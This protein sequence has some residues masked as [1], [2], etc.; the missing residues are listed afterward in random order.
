MPAS[1]VDLEAL[2]CSAAARS[3]WDHPIQEVSDISP[4]QFLSQL[5]VTVQSQNY[6]HIGPQQEILIGKSLVLSLS[7]SLCLS[8]SLS[9]LQIPMMFTQSLYTHLHIYIYIYIY[10]FIY[11]YIYIERES[12]PTDRA[13][14]KHFEGHALI[15]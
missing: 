11:I 10:V 1:A 6:I 3:S 13:C 2:T 14:P 15:P 8:L 9:H 5:Q 4:M 12:L 7:V